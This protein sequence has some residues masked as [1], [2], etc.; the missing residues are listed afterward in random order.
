MQLAA[1]V[2]TKGNGQNVQKRV[3]IELPSI[4]LHLFPTLAGTGR[5]SSSTNETIQ[6]STIAS[7]NK[8][9]QPLGAPSSPRL[10]FCG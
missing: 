5:G 1:N 4:A 6:L 7:A 9:Q 2:A 3:F 10:G 8:Y